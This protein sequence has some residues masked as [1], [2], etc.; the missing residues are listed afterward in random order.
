MKN[1]ILET[2]LIETNQAKFV[3]NHCTNNNDIGED[4]FY[5]EI[6]D[7]YEDAV[8]LIIYNLPF[9]LKS[10][11][12][13]MVDEYNEYF[14]SI[15]DEDTPLID[16]NHLPTEYDDAFNPIMS[17]LLIYINELINGWVFTFENHKE[18]NYGDYCYEVYII[19]DDYTQFE[20]PNEFGADITLY[21]GD[22]RIIMRK[23]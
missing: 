1:I 22:S 18:T 8:P 11:L 9:E 10:K 20:D 6:T 13:Q 15:G 16:L 19:G 4:D 14:K 17:E 2:L 3:G 7:G 12:I 21:Y 23:K 5:G